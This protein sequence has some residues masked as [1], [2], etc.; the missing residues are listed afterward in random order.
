MQLKVGA[1]LPDKSL[2]SANLAGNLP[3]SPLWMV[4]FGVHSLPT[5]LVRYWSVCG[6]SHA[7]AVTIQVLQHTGQLCSVTQ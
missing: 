2:T 3:Q 4:L 6:P 7:A 5:I 1:P